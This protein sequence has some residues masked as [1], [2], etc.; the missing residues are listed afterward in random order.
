MHMSDYKDMNNKDQQL[1]KT[2]A[3]IVNLFYPGMRVLGEAC[4]WQFHNEVHCRNPETTI[5]E[6]DSFAPYSTLMQR[7]LA[8]ETERPH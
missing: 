3:H 4:C 7:T 5:N 2:V 6:H 1:Q 8:T